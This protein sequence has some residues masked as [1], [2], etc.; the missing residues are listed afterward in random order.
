MKGWEWLGRREGGREGGREG[1]YLSFG[2]MNVDIYVSRRQVQGKVDEG[3]GVVGEDGRVDT[4]Q[5]ALDGHGFHLGGGR[6]GG[7]EDDGC[8]KTKRRSEEG[9]E[10][11]REGGRERTI[12]LLMNS[13]NTPLFILTNHIQG[14]EGGREGGREEGHAPRENSHSSEGGRKRGREGRT[15]HPIIDEQ[16]KDPLLHIEIRIRH[17]PVR[18]K[19]G[20]LLPFLPPSLPPAL[21][22][23]LP[24][25]RRRSRCPTPSLLPSLLPL[26]SEGGREGEVEF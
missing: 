15:H 9:R 7:R 5:G 12:Q 6:E 20:P 25:T 26:I 19:R 11:G 2:G 4:F 13:M 8:Q 1:T 24:P 22:L 14:K 23:L 3:V 10:E 18:L 21:P 17:I 16:Q